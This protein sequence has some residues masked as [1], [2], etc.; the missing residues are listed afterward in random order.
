MRHGSDHRA[1]LQSAP[2]GRNPRGERRTPLANRPVTHRKGEFGEPFRDRPTLG[3]RWKS[4][5]V[6]KGP[7]RGNVLRGFEDDLIEAQ[8][9]VRQRAGIP[10]RDC[11][12]RTIRG[13]GALGRRRLDAEG[14]GKLDNKVLQTVRKADERHSSQ[15]PFGLVRIALHK[16]TFDSPAQESRYVVVGLKGTGPDRHIFGKEI[17]PADIG[18]LREERELFGVGVAMLKAIAKMGQ[19]PVDRFTQRDGAMQS[20]VLGNADR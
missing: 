19:Q 9:C 20:Y 14:A 18:S 13:V 15:L 12:H 8:E 11:D 16:R 10:C 17:G 3:T 7:A 2:H 5:C 1:L 6:L 4:A